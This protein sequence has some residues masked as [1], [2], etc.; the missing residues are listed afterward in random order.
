VRVDRKL[1]SYGPT[2][3][4]RSESLEI[5]TESVAILQG[6]KILSDESVRKNSV[7]TLV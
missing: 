6:Q 4:G 5:S 2:R 7:L 1:R 3:S